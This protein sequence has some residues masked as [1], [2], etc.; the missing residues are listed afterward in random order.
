[1]VIVELLHDPLVHLA[2]VGGLGLLLTVAAFHKWRERQAFIDVLRR[3][4]H[5]LG[6]WCAMPVWALLIPVVELVAAVGLVLSL[7]YPGAAL[8]AVCLLVVYAGVL[9]LAVRQKSAIEDCG[10]HFGGRAQPPAPA[11][12]FRNLLLALLACNLLSPITERPLIWLDSFTLVF[13]FVSTAAVYLLANL[14]ISNR[15]SLR[16]RP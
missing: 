4:A 3:Y 13:V 8:P 9:T 10:C 7:G 14:L 1:M 2:S 11:L 16:Q 5:A 6:P 12:V 15:V